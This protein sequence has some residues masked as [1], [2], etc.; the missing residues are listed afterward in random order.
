MIKNNL[1]HVVIYMLY[2]HTVYEIRFGNE[3]NML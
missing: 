2:V 3:Q 1:L